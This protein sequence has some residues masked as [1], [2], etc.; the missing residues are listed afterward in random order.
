M[1]A[2]HR[3]MLIG[4]EWV[5]AE[6]KET[7]GV[8][9]PTTGEV[10]ADVPSGGRGDASKAVEAAREAFD[11][12]PWPKMTPSDRAKVV[13]R[14]ADL[15]EADVDRL[16]MMET[17]NQG[18]TIKMARDNDFPTGID[19]IRF[20]A[21]ASRNL[22]GKAAAEYTGL[23]TTIFRREPVGVVVC[24]TPWNYPWMMAVWKAVPA[25]AAGN[26][27]IIKP[28]SVTPLTTLEFAGLIEKAGVPKGV[29]NVVTGPGATV[30]E[31]LVTDPGVDVVGLTGD[32]VT[33]RRIMELASRTVKRLQ[34]ELGGKAPF[35]VLED[36][37]IEAATEG[38]VVGG[39][40]NAGQDCT[41]ATRI[42]VQERVH[43]RFMK[44]FTEKVGKIRIGDPKRR[45]VDMGPLVSQAQRK[46]VEEMVA[47]GE[48]EGGR[49][50]AGGKRPSLE[51][52]LGNGFFYEPTVFADVQQSMRICQE[53]IFGPVICVSPISTFEE[54]IEK[55]NDVP[56]GLAASIWTKDVSKAM[57]AGAM[58]RFGD[59][60]VNDHLPL[61][62][63]MPH[64]GFKQS[65]HG[66]DMSAY[67][68][69]D[70]TQV[71]FVYVDTSD[72]VRKPWYYTVYGD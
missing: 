43:E 34:L 7:F 31:A 20:F 21:G 67:T 6:R 1:S 32:T 29:V 38:A 24:I 45:D 39:F 4:G 59:V 52:S 27:V 58:L 37:D 33:G 47:V 72:A 50:V 26:S 56:Y 57:K 55:A 41:A 9:N 42:Y 16:A 46:K 64:G 70:Y 3:R 61:A 10:I 23:G 12:G 54:G 40:V 63:E 66:K 69:D 28:A 5:D 62:S 2:P 13:W 25:L 65:G 19:N 14:I 71:K 11:R 44:R 17:T 18:K 51:S 36:A 22:E 60:W 15:V 53:E 8:L 68:F 49:L 48:E 35:V 30:G